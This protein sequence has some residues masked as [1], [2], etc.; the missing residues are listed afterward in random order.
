MY[1]VDLEKRKLKKLSSAKF[2][3]L[4]VKETEDIEEW[5]RKN[6]DILKEDLLIISKQKKMSSGRKPDL[7]ALDK[8]GNLVIIELKRDDS[9]KNVYWQA[10]TYAAEFSDWSVNEIID[11]YRVYLESINND[12][13]DAKD[14]IDKF[15]EEDIVKINQ[16][17]RILLVSKEF[18]QDVLKAV[19]WLIDYEVD[20]RCVKL[21]P[22]KYE[23]KDGKDQIFLDS[24]VIIPI[25][26][27]K[28]YIVG[29]V[30]KQK[31]A[32]RVHTSSVSFEKGDFDKITLKEKIKGTLSRR[33]YWT[34]FLKILLSEDKSFDR[35]EIKEKLF[36][37]GIGK[38]MGQTGRCLSHISQLLTNPS[39][40]HLR[41]IVEFESPKEKAGEVKNNY[42]IFPEYREVVREILYEIEEGNNE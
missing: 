13:T 17:Q 10:I 6:P 9:G 12:N 15:V 3:D 18:H 14:I 42:R 1:K 19:L 41:Q 7:L 32:R 4:K 25:P 20:I 21:T 36:S 23:K 33:S 30:I 11:L 24:A 27:I 2:S 34:L 22:Y 38:N 29:K 37:S 31:E 28:D 5:I 39:T 8:S 16:K 35:E 26:E 40:P